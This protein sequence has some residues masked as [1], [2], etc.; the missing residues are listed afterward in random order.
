MRMTNDITVSGINKVKTE[1]IVAEKISDTRC[2]PING[3]TCIYKK[4]T[5]YLLKNYKNT[6]I[7]YNGSNDNNGWHYIVVKKSTTNDQVMF[8]WDN[9]HLKDMIEVLENTYDLEGDA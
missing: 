1:V 4:D 7:F 6:K 8:R 2:L 3:R 5:Y 9:N